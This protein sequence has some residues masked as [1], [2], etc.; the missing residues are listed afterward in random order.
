MRWMRLSIRGG[1]LQ[2]GKI[3]DVDCDVSRP[4]FQRAVG[5][6]LFRESIGKVAVF[7]DMS[8]A[9]DL[10]DISYPLLG[11]TFTND[12]GGHLRLNEPVESDEQWIAGAD[13]RVVDLRIEELLDSSG[14]HLFHDA[15]L[16]QRGHYATMSIRA[17]GQFMRR[18]HEDASGFRIDR[19]HGSLLE[20][21][22]L[23]AAESESVI[24][25]EIGSR[26]RVR[27]RAGHDEQGDRYSETLHG[28]SERIDMHFEEGAS[29]DRADGKHAF[30]L[31]ESQT[32][33][34][35]S[36]NQD[37]RNLSARQGSLAFENRIASRKTSIGLPE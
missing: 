29:R 16:V 31:I 6:C 1:L 10:N 21:V 33:P 30:G 7:D 14:S 3:E 9:I 28:T 18:V 25:F 20:R 8:S 36:G 13:E 15:A 26:G 17:Q 24:F 37:H 34:L 5:E 4:Q 27:G 32:R 35:A 23:L 2:K 12:L 22:Q 19:G 11:E